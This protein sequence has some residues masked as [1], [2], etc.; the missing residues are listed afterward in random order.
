MKRLW[1]YFGMYKKRVILCFT[2]TFME[3]IFFLMIPTLMSR[4]FDIGLN[5]QDKPYI[6]Q[7]GGI[8]I[9]CAVMAMIIGVYE[10]YVSAIA[11][12][13]LGSN[14]REALFNKVMDFSSANTD[15][16]TNSTLITRL[17][18]DVNAVQT[19]AIQFMRMIFVGGWRIVIAL[20]LAVRINA[21]LTLIIVGTI[22]I[23]LTFLMIAMR[24]VMPWFSVMQKQMDDLNKKTQDNTRAQRVVK[25]FVRREYEKEKFNK[26]NLRLT[27]ILLKSN[28][29]IMSIVPLSAVVMNGTIAAV[30]WFGGKQT[31]V[32]T[33]GFGELNTFL[34]YAMQVCAAI[35]MV[36]VCAGQLGK[37][38]AAARR[39]FEVL[40]TSPVIQNSTK[41]TDL[42]IRSGEIQFRNVSFQ[43]TKK[44]PKKALDKIDFAVPSG[45]F[46][47]IIGSTGEGK[48][49]LLSLISRQYDTSSGTVS[50]G[51]YDVK[52]YSLETLREAVAYV[53]Q[54]NVLFSGTIRENIRWGNPT[55]SDDEIV[56]VC[57]VAQ[58]H[59]FIMGFEKGYDTWIEQGGTNVSGGQRQRLCIARALAKKANI[60][61]LDDST[62]ALDTTTEAKLLNCLR[63]DYKDTTV[64]LVAQKISSV[65]NA[66]AILVLDKG[67]ISG[68]GTH[69]ELLRNNKVYQEIYQSQI[70]EVA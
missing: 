2:A 11:S 52:D 47:A 32:G 33:M 28:G 3:S 29:I 30:L 13:G 61:L 56:S 48:S 63:T 27:K 12:Q 44:D 5:N 43:Y 14:L 8:M 59:E 1:N 67:E 31:G 54:N 7:T 35:G 57:A 65:I 21:R 64:L 36:A 50:V 51:G 39:V 26:P 60:L 10:N 58:A 69:E 15:Q 25:A 68:L 34:S 4:I 23:F 55:A 66:D 38:V 37:A 46:W 18:S 22:I 53:P 16:F 24:L 42:M 9:L 41:N 6:Y 49:S 40:E 19:G 17:N 45:Q 70:K 62:S 20:I